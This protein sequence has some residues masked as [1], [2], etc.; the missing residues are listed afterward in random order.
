MAAVGLSLSANTWDSFVTTCTE[1]YN[2]HRMETLFT[3]ITNILFIPTP[4]LGGKPT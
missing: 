4:R 2:G 3:F 1:Y